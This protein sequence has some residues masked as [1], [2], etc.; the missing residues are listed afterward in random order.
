MAVKVEYTTCG[1]GAEVSQWLNQ[2]ARDAISSMSLD[3]VDIPWDDV[4]QEI[5]AIG[6]YSKGP[7]ASQV[8]A[9]LV[10]DLVAMNALRPFSARELERLGGQ[11]AFAPVAWQNSLRY[12]DGCLWSVPLFADPYVILYRADM[13]EQ[14]GVDASTA[15]TSIENLE[16]TLRKLVASGI[17]KPLFLPYINLD[18]FISIH[19]AMS[20]IWACGG[21]LLSSDHKTAC[22]L[23]PAALAGMKAFFRL[24]RFLSPGSTTTDFSV[25]ARDFEL[26]QTAITLGNLGAAQKV[27][28]NLPPEKR[29]LVHT[30]PTL[31]VSL[32]GGSSLVIWKHTRQEDQAVRL[33]QFLTS[34]EFQS[35]YPQ[36]MG[37]L[38]ARQDILLSQFSPSDP[39]Q[40]GFLKAMQHGRPFPVA[41][42]AGLLEDQFSNGLM[43]IWNRIL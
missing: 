5:T 28:A 18:K 25:S 20:W 30:T 38:P 32:V 40:A 2:V 36:R 42:L 11:A 9:P 12:A 37:L 35:Q 24:A 4:K 27:L 34:A 3:V 31:G 39:F 33:V 8:G 29:Q 19:T 21:S 7:D 17:E 41:K 22:F 1:H 16:E 23:E 43:R 14:A 13:L 15:F 10:N 6:I 26:G